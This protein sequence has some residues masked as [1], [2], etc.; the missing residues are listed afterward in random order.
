MDMVV[1]QVQAVRLRVDLQMAAKVTRSGDHALHVDIVGFTLADQ[2]AG[3]MSDDRDMPIAHRANNAVGLCL[4]RQI[5]IRV[6]G[7]HDDIELGQAG[8]RQVEAAVIQER[9][10]DLLDPASVL[11]TNQAALFVKN[12]A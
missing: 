7:C 3:R 9:A 1:V 4:A 12:D 6:N 5:E 11:R 8:V 2:S 10:T